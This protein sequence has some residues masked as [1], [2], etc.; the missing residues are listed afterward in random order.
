LKFTKAL[1]KQE[2]QNEFWDPPKM[3]FLLTTFML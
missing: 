3:S 2:G 1:T